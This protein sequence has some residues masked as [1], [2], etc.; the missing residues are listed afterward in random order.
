MP[1][2]VS[3]AKGLNIPVVSIPPE[4]AD[5]HFGMFAHFAPMDMLASS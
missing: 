1:D 4:M 5:E 3:H 2:R